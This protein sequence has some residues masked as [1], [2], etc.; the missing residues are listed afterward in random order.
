M[1]TMI[2]SG[3][4]RRLANYLIVKSIVETLFV[5]ALALGFYLTAFAPYIHGVLD[6]ADAQQVAGWAVDQS[7]PQAS[8]EVQLYIDGR[9]V[10]DGKADVAR[11]DVKAA[12]RAADERHGFVFATPPLPA[13]EHEARVYAVHAS[14]AGVRR[15]LQLIGKPLTFHVTAN[16][17]KDT[18]TPAQEQR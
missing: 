11:P 10:S 2:D 4:R 12:G 14:G 15:T 18:S 9:F 3:A 5:A 7:S 16:D 1:E 8:V 6:M 17:A 13:G